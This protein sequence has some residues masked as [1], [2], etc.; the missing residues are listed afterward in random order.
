LQGRH[1]VIHEVRGAGVMRG[2]ALAVDAQPVIDGALAA[3][4][5]VNRTAERVVR[6]LPPFTVSGEEIEQAVGILDRV[7]TQVESRWSGVEVKA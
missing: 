2:L 4:L 1:P 7:L 6:M 3:G 5:L